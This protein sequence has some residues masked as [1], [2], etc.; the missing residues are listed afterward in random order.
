MDIYTIPVIGVIVQFLG[1]LVEHVPEAG[2]GIVAVA[3]PLG[4]GAL[5]GV[6]CERSGVVNIGIEGTMLTAAFMGWVSGIVAVGILGPGTP[7][8]LGIT[9]P[10]LIALLG[11]I[12]SAV[13]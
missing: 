6:V 12:G 4:F 1:Y 8:P 13:L 11:A 10:L 3:T 2:P 9:L 7:G 5:C